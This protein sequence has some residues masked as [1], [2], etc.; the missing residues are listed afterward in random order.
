MK[1]IKIKTMSSSQKRLKAGLP[2]EA[3]TRLLTRVLQAKI[4]SAL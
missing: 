1:K 2:Q 4:V 3:Y